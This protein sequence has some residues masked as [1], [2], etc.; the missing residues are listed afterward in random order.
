MRKPL[1]LLALL[2]LPLSVAAAP[3]RLCWHGPVDRYVIE[4]APT[5]EGPWQPV[6][7][8]LLPPPCW[9]PPDGPLSCYRVRSAAGDQISVGSTNVWCAPQPPTDLDGTVPTPPPAPVPPLAAWD[10][11]AAT[12]PGNV[13]LFGGTTG[14]WRLTPSAH[15][16]TQALELHSPGSRTWGYWTAPLVPIEAGQTYHLSLWL[17]LEG[18]KVAQ[19]YVSWRSST[20]S[21]LTLQLLSVLSD[22]QGWRAVTA[23]AVAPVGAT[24]LRVQVRADLPTTGWLRVDEV[25]LRQEGP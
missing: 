4:S 11:E 19:V 9:E 13:G 17:A 21:E 22:T 12:V 14:T 1:A 8:V 15:A 18:V 16:G 24:G 5:Q 20:G 23:E 7:E 6:G 10:F 3:P 25:T 2:A